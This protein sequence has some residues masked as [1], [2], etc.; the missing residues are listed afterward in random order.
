MN[1]EDLME[2]AHQCALEKG[3]WDGEDRPFGDQVTN[4]H[5]EISEAWEEYRTYGMDPNFFIYLI[6]GSP[7]PEGLAVELADLLIR[8]CDTCQRYNIPLV[9]A[10][11][12]KMAYNKT[13]TYRHGGKIC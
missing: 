2:E 3:W 1:I 13:R 10:L 4:F 5:A 8:I 11:E 12:E 9:R 6:P 7:K